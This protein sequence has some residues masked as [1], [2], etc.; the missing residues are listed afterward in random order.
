MRAAICALERLAK[1]LGDTRPIG[2]PEVLVP[3]PVARVSAALPTR[4][5]D[6]TLRRRL[7]ARPSRKPSPADRAAA[8]PIF[9]PPTTGRR[10]NEAATRRPAMHERTR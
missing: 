2:L 10:R 1:V 3:G 7:D 8:A 9:Y 6:R 5:L 4:G